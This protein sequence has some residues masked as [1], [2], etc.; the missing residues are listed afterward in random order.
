MKPVS[1]VDGHQKAYV[2]NHVF[3]HEAPVM[4]VS[5]PDGDWC[6]LCGELHGESGMEYRV[7]G[8]EHLLSADKT[9]SE[10]SDLLP[11]WEAERSEIGGK[12]MRTRVAP[13]G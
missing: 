13:D 5:R 7:V 4:L 6:F 8:I 1:K 2:C 12:W 9:L 3:D 10:V 11:D